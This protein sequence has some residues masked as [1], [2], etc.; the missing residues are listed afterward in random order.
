MSTSDQ[1]IWKLPAPDV[2]IPW[3]KEDQHWVLVWNLQSVRQHKFPGMHTLDRKTS[4]GF[5]NRTFDQFNN[6]KFPAPDMCIPWKKPALGSRMKLRISSTTLSI[7]PKRKSRAWTLFPSFL[8]QPRLI[9][10]YSA[11]SLNLHQ[12]SNVVFHLTLR[13]VLWACL[14]RPFKNF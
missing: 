12:K 14:T 2:C 5:K 4:N 13:Y 11:L 9:L 6:I 8:T 3:R 10:S 7:G 1:L